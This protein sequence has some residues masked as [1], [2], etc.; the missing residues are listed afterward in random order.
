[1]SNTNSAIIGSEDTTS[2][3]KIID[4]IPD[5]TL[6]IG[7]NGL[8]IDCNK[9]TLKIFGA[10]NRDEIIGKPPGLLA[11]QNQRNGNSSDYESRK[12][13][14]KAHESGS[15]A[16]FF[17]HNTLD[18]RIFQA[19]VTLSEIE[20]EGETCLLTT[21]AD[22]TGQVRMEENHTLIH[23]NPYA[24][25][26]M[27]ATLLVSEVNQA[28][29]EMSGYRREEW[30]G[31]SFKD[32]K[33]IERN[34]QTVNEA[35]Q[36]KKK[37]T[38]KLVID[39]PNGI[40]TLEYSH[41]PI[42]DDSGHIYKIFAIFSDL[43]DLVE[44][45]HESE[46]LISENPASI[47]TMDPT[48]R[49]TATNPAFL[50]LSRVSKEKLLAMRMQDF[51]IL[52]R[53]GQSFQNITASKKAAKGRLV[54][55]FG[56]A[57]KILDFTY[58]PIVDANG[59]VSSLVAMYLD[60]TDQVSYIDEIKTFIKENPHAIITVKPDLSITDV[61][62]AFS[63]MMG[64]SYE[65]S[66][67]LKLS[68]IKVLEREGKTLRDSLVSKKP[69]EGKLVVDVPAGIRHV[70]CVYIPI[71]DKKG[72]VQKFI[73]IFT[74]LTAI[75]S[76]VQY[77]SKSVANIQDNISS[78]AQGDTNFTCTVL[79]ADEHS[80]S[81]REEFVKI[82]QAVETA[83]NAIT[84][85]VHDSNTIAKS[86]IAGDLKYRSDPTIHKGD[87][88][89]VI[90]GM[91]QTLDSIS[92]PIQES[93]KIADSYAKYN[94]TAR[95][96]PSLSVKGDWTQFVV[97]LNNIGVQVSEAMSLISKN[98]T[99]LVTS[100]EEVNASIEEVLAGSQQIASNTSKVSQNAEQGNEGI[101]QV[102]KAMEDLNVTVG[103]VSQKAE[104]VSIASNAANDLAKKGVEQAKQS[105]KA[106]GD[107]KLST[108]EVDTIVTG[109]NSQMDEI[110]KIVR[111]ISDIANQTNLLALNAAIEAARAGEAG[112]GFAVV[113][114]EVKSLAQDSRKSAENIEYMI[115]ALQTKAKQATEAMGKSTHAVY[116][117]SSSLEQTLISFNQIAQTIEDIN[118]NTVEVA[119]ASE[120]Q[121]ASVEEVTAS[122]QE[123]S[124]LVQNTSHEAGDTAAATEETS[125]SIDE[126][127]RIMNGVVTIAD[128]IAGEMTKFKVA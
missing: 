118:R 19:R 83:R 100:T 109:I 75:K 13:I 31:R 73:E 52:E 95:F 8:F 61:N 99:E 110:G 102:L 115:A 16:F 44:K 32:F 58:I 54:V 98:V 24:L 34:G 85:L 50:E 127:G 33:I 93:M 25:V 39:F 57:V 97:A 68:D 80:V 47:I 104:S 105:E 103:A 78:L 11:P 41:I 87:Y 55:D 1:M 35:V 128:S 22:I 111:L 79:D 51:N 107:I 86:A 40:K 74:D 91:N 71:M 106:M 9:A 123:V 108:N 28:F 112:R 56:W 119:S 27:D 36:N 49:I 76:M 5:A 113:A 114:A 96:D 48:G 120:E 66:L 81:A 12:Y 46:S 23:E 18:G 125:A 122:I 121:A 37:A 94:F 126:I 72:E 67:T 92:T 117:G 2:L 53:E 30:I 6:I 82:S 45:I 65:Q 89:A 14:Q 38:G 26:E 77:L 3:K 29:L 4:S 88:R 101:A 60:V 15:I 124:Y 43:T 116:D 62:P 64:Y 59:K 7:K 20:Y 69:V 21:I 90:E 17:D 70:E 42:Q 63:R 10:S 84:R